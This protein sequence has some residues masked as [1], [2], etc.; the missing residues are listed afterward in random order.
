MPNIKKGDK[1][2]KRYSCDNIKKAIDAVN[3]G[4][5]KHKASAMYGIPRSTLIFRLS[6]KFTKAR[7]GPASILTIEEEKTLVNLILACH[8]QGF[9][10]RKEDLQMS[11]KTYLD[12]NE[13]RK[14]PF[15]NNLQRNGWY[16]AFL[17]RH[18]CLT[19]R[20]PEGVSSASACVSE[21]DIRKWFGKSQPI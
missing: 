13:E 19:E 15:T 10:R 4:M 14:T 21:S 2:N 5:S 12:G 17:K 3:N 20:Q 6:S 16:K 9:P 11:I 7:P 1:Y 8:R 18:L